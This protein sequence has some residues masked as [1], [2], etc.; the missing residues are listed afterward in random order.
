MNM[1]LADNELLI[2]R[3]FD[4][5]AATLFALWTEPEHFRRWMGPADFDCPE[6]TM[7]VRVGGAYSAM[8]RSAAQGENRFSGV[9]REIVPNRRLVFTFAWNNAG[10]SDGIEMLITITFEERNGRTVQTFHQRPFR[11]VESRDAHRG[12]WIGTFDKLAAYAEH[13]REQFA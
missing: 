4:A 11:N 10:P 3:S 7:D 6:A 12:G 9:Y 1:P 8:I 2:V 13:T 5:P